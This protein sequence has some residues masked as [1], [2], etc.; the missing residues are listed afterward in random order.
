MFRV[1]LFLVLMC[2]AGGCS[3][4]TPAQQV[5]QICDNLAASPNYCST[6]CATA[7]GALGICPDESGAVIAHAESTPF[8]DCTSA[9]LFGRTC[10]VGGGTQQMYDCACFS[11]CVEARS[12][13]FQM[14]FS[15]YMR[16]VERDIA[17]VCY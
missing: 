10:T 3:N 7:R 4:P 9:C 14:V 12:N 1:S 5:R 8:S 15:T 13:D 17:S 16:C 2:G 6:A 11:R